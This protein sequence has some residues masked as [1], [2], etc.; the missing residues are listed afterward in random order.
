MPWVCHECH[1]NLLKL[2]CNEPTLKT[3]PILL[4]SYNT[5]TANIYRQISKNICSVSKIQWV[6]PDSFRALLV[7]I[8]FPHVKST[9]ILFYNHIWENSFA[10]CVH[11]GQFQ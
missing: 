8:V 3:R 10:V 7:K 2:C 6:V 4:L 1:E 11:Y 5:Y 9:H